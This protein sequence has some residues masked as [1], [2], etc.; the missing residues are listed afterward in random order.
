MENPDVQAL[1]SQN[2]VVGD[3]ERLVCLDEWAAR[4]HRLAA[5]ETAVDE[6]LE[7]APEDILDQPVIDQLESLGLDTD[8]GEVNAVEASNLVA[9]AQEE[10]RTRVRD[11]VTSILMGDRR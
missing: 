4:H 11:L 2:W 5:A 9:D 3:D 8:D 10:C 7:A 6:A 1:T